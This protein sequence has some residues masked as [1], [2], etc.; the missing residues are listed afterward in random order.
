MATRRP[1]RLHSA[2]YVGFQQYFVTLCAFERQ[3]HLVSPPAFELITK[4]LLRSAG[5]HG[6]A[7]LAYCCMPDHLHLLVEGL[8]EGADLRPFIGEFK[9]KT[10]FT[11]KGLSGASLWQDGF[12]DHVLRSNECARTRAPYL[13]ASPVRAGLVRHPSEWPY[14]GSE[15]YALRELLESVR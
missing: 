14:L 1:P 4:Q 6:F 12:H 9:Q 3:P 8:R 11:Y 2:Q 5:V 15:R 7:V 10:A 13:L